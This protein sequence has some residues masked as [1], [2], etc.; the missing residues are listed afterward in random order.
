V[1]R[2]QSAEF[3]KLYEASDSELD[4]VRRAALFIAMNDLLVR[5][6]VVIPVPARRD[7]SALAN[8]LHAPL[9]GRDTNFCALHDVQHVL[10][11]PV[12]RLLTHQRLHLSF[13]ACTSRAKSPRDDG[14]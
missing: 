10:R 11:R 9:S 12:H 2:W 3:D 14:S 7:V 8:D 13:V 4:P 1:T 6:V 5:N